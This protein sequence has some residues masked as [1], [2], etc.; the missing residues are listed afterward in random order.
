M[1]IPQAF[2]QSLFLFFLLKTFADPFK[3]PKDL[4]KRFCDYQ[5]SIMKTIDCLQVRPGVR[6]GPA[7]R[8]RFLPRLC[9]LGTPHWAGQ[10]LRLGQRGAD[11]VRG[12]ALRVPRDDNEQGV[13]PRSELRFQARRRC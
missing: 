4:Y 12:A 6:G 3:K 11:P 9:P 5:A 2:E 1:S 7:G 13:V 8:L 10:A